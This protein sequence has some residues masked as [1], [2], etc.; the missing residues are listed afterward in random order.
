[1]SR[2]DDGIF[3]LLLVLPWWVSVAVS[4]IAYFGL[5]VV[6]PSMAIDNPLLK[7]VA[8]G[9]RIFAPFVALFL[10]LPAPISALNAW[11]KRR[12]LNSQKS[13]AS[14]RAL[15]WKEFEELVAEAY[16]RRGYNV[17]E[18]RR[19]GADG[20]VDV[21]LSK[22]GQTHL[23]QCKQW[24]TQKV[25]VKVVR[26]MF[27][28]M[29]AENAASVIII[30]SGKFTQEARNFAGGKPIELVDGEAL[31]QM[32]IPLTRNRRAVVT[33]QP[34]ARSVAAVKEAPEEYVAGPP[35]IPREVAAAKVLGICDKC[36]A[37][38]KIL[39]GR[40][41]Y[42]WKCPSCENNMPIKEFCPSC[43]KKMK[44][45]K[46]KNTFFI[47]CEPCETETLYCEFESG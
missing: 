44:L 15:G 26:E 37:Q 38:A 18:N 12:L 45:R 41:S 23:V 10:L 7:G 31:L 22:N 11:R 40:Y 5:A 1:M 19:G 39:W 47:K 27:G 43:K 42:Y 24:K 29:T 17:T 16:R 28:V 6:L 14:I 30:S 3:E 32:I 20:G 36:S 4:G 2:K 33:E 13:I 34:V 9:T 46:Q 35:P 21:R 25:G 8:Q